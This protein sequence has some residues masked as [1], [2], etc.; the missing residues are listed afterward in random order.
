MREINKRREVVSMKGIKEGFTLIELMVG[1]A[2]IGVMAAIA[3][4]KFTNVTNEAK[5]ASIQSNLVNIRTMIDMYYVKNED[6]PSLEMGVEDGYLGGAEDYYSKEVLSSTPAYK[7]LHKYGWGEKKFNVED[8]NKVS[9][10]RE[11][12]ID[13]F[14]GDG[15]GGW[16]YIKATKSQLDDPY[17]G[18]YF[19][20]HN[21][22]IRANLTH[23]TY[24]SDLNWARF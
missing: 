5:I 19:R 16:C 11:F 9:E 17:G 12:G 14:L 7:G 6:I 18:E 10:V 1:I 24:G 15:K 13:G 20:K 23:G 2:I 3:L 4:P 22:Q 21:G 8:T